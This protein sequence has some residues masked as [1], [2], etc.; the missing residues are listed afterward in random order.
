MSARRKKSMHELQELVRY[1]RLGRGPREVSRLLQMSPNTERKYR[2]AIGEAGLLGG[3]PDDIANLEDL[4]EAIKKS[5][6]PGTFRQRSTVEGYKEEITE[7]LANGSGAQA[8]YDFLRL[9]YEE[10]FTGSLSAI[11]RMCKRIKV[12]R[13]VQP[14]DVVIPVE[15]DPGQVAQV[16]FGYLGKIYDPE[17]G[18]I[19]KVW[20]FVMVLGYSRKMFVDLVFD[21]KTTTWIDLHIRAFEYFGGI[22]A[23]V[24][25]DNLKA[26]VIKA[27]FTSADECEINRSYRELARHYGF[28]I[29]PTP[30]YQPEKKGKVESGVKYVKNNF[31]K[32]RTF[33]DI[34]D[35]RAQ[36]REWLEKVANYRIHGTTRRRPAEMFAAEEAEHLLALP[37]TRFDIVIWRKA[38]VH[39]DTHFQ[40][41]GRLYSVHFKNIGKQ[42]WARANS[43][44]V[45]AYLDD[46]RLATHDRNGNGRRSTIKAHL[47]DYRV[48]WAERSRDFWENKAEAIGSEVGAYVRAVF[49]SD[50]ELSQLRPAQAIVTHLEKFPVG[51]ACAAAARA[52]YYGAYSYKA[53]KGILQ[54]GLDLTE[55]SPWDE[56][57]YGVIESPRHARDITEISRRAVEVRHGTN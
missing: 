52:H 4:R 13:G 40:F 51:R 24:V 47:P 36:L 15:T 34:D 35:A 25:P 29:D 38:K 53:I 54:K 42:V 50:K 11:K 48:V 22:P 44:T 17:S 1:H 31:G 37:A 6:P 21:Q 46:L 55:P 20:I 8:I 41:D 9:K 57:R 23:V 18:N 16:D 14:G 30:P 33:K 32:P 45:E 5:F 3:S 19:R 56:P 10:E 28:L 12:E 43:T 2:L 7:K 27:A 39:Q 49:E 26:A